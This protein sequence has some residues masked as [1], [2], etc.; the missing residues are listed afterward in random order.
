[1]TFDNEF[2]IRKVSKKEHDKI[3][4]DVTVIKV[5]K[6]DMDIETLSKIISDLEINGWMATDKKKVKIEIVE[7]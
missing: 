6:N 4:K 2:T 3:M 7:E 1:M 5:S